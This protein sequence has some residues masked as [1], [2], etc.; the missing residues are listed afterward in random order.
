M[1]PDDAA[2]AKGLILPRLTV[3]SGNQASNAPFH[4]AVG[5]NAPDNP[6][7]ADAPTRQE[8]DARFDAAR[9]DAR[10]DAAVL[11]ADFAD[12]KGSVQVGFAEIRQD[13]AKANATM[14]EHL[15]SQLKWIV[16][17]MFGAIA[18]GVTV[19]TFVL[20][21][22]TPKPAPAPA[23]ALQPILIYPQPAAAAAAPAP[24]QAP[25]PPVTTTPSRP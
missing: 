20:N 9:S 12:L 15:S 14:H 21:N 1:A 22:A 8:L 10:A 3:V 23:Q 18:A 11:R 2:T 13:L 6:L 24:T 16:A 7:M 4:V 25:A 5:E 17:T 19:M